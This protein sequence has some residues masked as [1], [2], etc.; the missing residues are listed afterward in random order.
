MMANIFF[1]LLQ[2]A[3]MAKSEISLID[4]GF[5]GPWILFFNQY[6]NSILPEYP[7]LL[8]VT[9]S[10]VEFC[11]TL[12][13]TTNFGLFQIEIVCRRHFLNFDELA[14]SSPKGGETPWE[15][16][17]LLVT[18]AFSFFHGVF[19]HLLLLTRKN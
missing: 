17:K 6:F 12:S 10:R 18:S 16:E 4:T 3:H 11:I 8:F 15:K 5:I 7:L 2:V 9:V 14:E 13:Q 19:K 1:P